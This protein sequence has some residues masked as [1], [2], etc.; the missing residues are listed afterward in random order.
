MLRSLSLLASC[1]AVVSWAGAQTWLQTTG[2]G[3][4]QG[5]DSSS[6]A[7]Y[8]YHCQALFPSIVE[9]C[10]NRE[11]NPGH[12]HGRL[13][14]YRYTIGAV[15]HFSQTCKVQPAHWRTG[16]TKSQRSSDSI[17]RTAWPSGLRRQLKALVRKGVG[18]NPTAVIF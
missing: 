6:A 5:F 13:V 18:S 16:I 17:Q 14:C 11:S 3:D 12:K 7:F 15:F 10:A 8:F 2:G 1:A 4:T 9:N